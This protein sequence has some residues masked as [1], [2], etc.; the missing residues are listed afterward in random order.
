[1]SVQNVPILPTKR[2]HV[3]HPYR[4]SESTQ[5]LLNGCERNFQLNRLLVPAENG[6]EREAPS[7][8]MIRGHAFG[9]A[10]QHYILT[11]SM[12]EALYV[13]WMEYYPEVYDEAKKIYMWRVVNNLLCCKDAMDRIRQR[14]EVAVF[15]GKPA[16]ELSFRLDIDDKWHFVGYI[17]VVLYDTYDK[18]YV[19]LEI[20][21]T[22][23]N[24]IDLK[25]MY[26]NQGQGLAYSI[27]IDQ[28][29]GEEQAKYGVLYF[30]CRDQQKGTFIP[31]VYTFPFTKTLLDR[32]RWFYTLQLDVQRLNTMLA[33][34]LFPMRGNHCISFNRV[35]QH[36]GTC[37][38]TAGDIAR[39]IPSE[40][41][42]YDFRYQLDDVISNH[43][44]R[45]GKQQDDI[46]EE[47][48]D[49]NVEVEEL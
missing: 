35:C 33:N 16:C 28:I 43:L 25:P 42:E 47:R 21:T 41:V 20:K 39:E 31:D 8:P 17:D 45:V 46:V 12:E 27:A 30:V 49:I 38:F 32:L 22:T 40:E 44:E 6:R 13:L 15:G 5:N 23:F 7:V 11:G 1:M 14:Y 4:L 24:L 3:T 2:A 26:R 18:I 34:Q 10:V 29:V 37:G 48:K 9:A 19:I 36:F